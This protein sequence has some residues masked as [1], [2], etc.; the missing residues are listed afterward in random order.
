MLAEKEQAT[1]LE[2]FLRRES[3][4][5]FHDAIDESNLVDARRNDGIDQDNQ[6]RKTN[7]VQSVQLRDQGTIIQLVQ[8]SEQDDLFKDE[9]NIQTL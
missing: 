6:I 4:F 8:S 2:G 3:N 7:M 9:E 1:D 5:D